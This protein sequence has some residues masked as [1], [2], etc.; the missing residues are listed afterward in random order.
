M[1]RHGDDDGDESEPDENFFYIDAFMPG[2]II[3]K[4]LHNFI[5]LY[6]GALFKNKL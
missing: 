5:I 2:V 6:F 1:R 4:V 3:D